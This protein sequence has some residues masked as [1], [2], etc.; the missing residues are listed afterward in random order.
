MPN[1]AYRYFF[2]GT[3]TRKKLGQEPVTIWIRVEQGS[4]SKNFEFDCPTSLASNLRWF[5]SLSDLS[6]A[7]Q[8]KRVAPSCVRKREMSVVIP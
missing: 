4:S 8:L 1:V 7:S 2:T 3:Y 6:Q 5:E